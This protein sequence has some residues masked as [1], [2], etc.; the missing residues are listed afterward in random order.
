M[1]LGNF[2]TNLKILEFLV[3]INQVYNHASLMYLFNISEATLHEIQV[4]CSIIMF[5]KMVGIKNA[6]VYHLFQ[7]R[8]FQLENLTLN[9]INFGNSSLESFEFFNF[10]LSFIDFGKILQQHFQ[11]Y[12]NLLFQ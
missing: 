1:G 3:T 4:H 7:R 8:S 12:W 11:K 10:Q 9:P 5:S 6:V 2:C